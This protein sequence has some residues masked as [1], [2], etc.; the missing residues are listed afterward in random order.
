VA[1]LT[2]ATRAAGG[3]D[4]SLA[5]KKDGSLW[6]WGDNQFG[7]LGLPVNTI[8]NPAPPQ[9][10]PG[11]TG[12]RA[13]AAGTFYSLALNLDGTVF[14]WGRNDAGQLGRACSQAGCVDSAVPTRIPNLF[15]VVGIAAGGSHALAILNDGTVRAWGDNSSGQL[16]DN[17]TTRRTSPVAVANLNGVRTVAGG[18]S[19]SLAVKYDGTAWAWGSNASGQLGDN[20]APTGHL[21]PARV[22]TLGGEN[23]VAAG[24]SHSLASQSEPIGGAIGEAEQRGGNFPCSTH[25]TSSPVNTGTGDFWHTFSDLSIPGRGAPLDFVRTYNSTAASEPG[26]SATPLGYGWTF[27]YGVSISTTATAAKITEEAGNQV[28][29]DLISGVYVAHVPR[30]IA[31]LV[32]DGATYTYTRRATEIL[33]FDVATKR[34]KSKQTLDPNSTTTIN[35]TSATQWVITDPGGRTLTIALAGGLIQSVTD[36]ASPARSLHFYY[37]DG[38]GNLTRVTDVNKSPN[39]HHARSEVFKRPHQGTR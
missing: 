4:H 26:A 37:E 34:L 6:V 3:S 2:D 15:G 28:D 25:N 14:S 13:V 23:Q 33:K 12:F 9:Q 30:N 24:S 32:S 10:I 16:G 21:I 20:M 7:Q 11:L 8:G 5:I 18:S 31:T 36:N 27:S 22:G 38:A 35:Y 29:F 1:N 39:A 19:H 17:S